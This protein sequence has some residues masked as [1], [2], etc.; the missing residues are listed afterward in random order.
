MQIGETALHQAAK[1]GHH[2]TVAFLLEHGADTDAQN[3]VIRLD[4]TC[5]L[6]TY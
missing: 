5:M 4:A 6:L 2:A 3:K 1:Y